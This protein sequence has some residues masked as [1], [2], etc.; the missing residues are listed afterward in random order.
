MAGLDAFGTALERSDMQATP[1]FTPVANVTNFAGP[2]TEREIYDST[3]HDSPE[4][5]REFVGGLK[6]GGEVTMTVNFDP[7]AHVT[8]YGDYADTVARD[9]RLVLPGGGYE[10]AFSAFMNGFSS[11]EPV[12]GKMTGEVKLKITGKPDLAAA[13]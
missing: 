1:T 8:L 6:N 13:A 9:Y 5:W 10:W 4:Q 7:S 11:E 12:D 3:A 2:E